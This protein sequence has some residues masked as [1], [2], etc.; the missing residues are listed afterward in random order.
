MTVCKKTLDN[1]G[2]E[3]FQTDTEGNFGRENSYRTHPVGVFLGVLTPQINDI[4]F[5]ERSQVII[6][7]HHAKSAPNATQDKPRLSLAPAVTGQRVTSLLHLAAVEK[8][9]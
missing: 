7:P 5:G 2:L 1:G 3:N 6:W 9:S 8:K 4:N